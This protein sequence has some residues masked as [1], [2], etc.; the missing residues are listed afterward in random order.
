MNERT[1]QFGFQ[2]SIHSVST[3]PAICDS[4]LSHSHSHSRS[5]SHSQTPNRIVMVQLIPFADRVV[6]L[7]A[8]QVD[9]VAF[10]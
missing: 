6:M 7:D 5:R 1:F 10:P 9:F 3:L 8:S 2:I 4:S